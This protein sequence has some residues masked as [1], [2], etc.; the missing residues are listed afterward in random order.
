[1]LKEHTK[2][3]WEKAFITPQMH[4]PRI[5]II[6][7]TYKFKILPK[8]T[9]LKTVKCCFFLTFVFGNVTFEK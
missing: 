8:K 2:R 6:L 5:Q 1:M 7:M 3:S 4:L 9:Q